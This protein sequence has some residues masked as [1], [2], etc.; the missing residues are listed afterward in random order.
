MNV[1]YLVA[2][3]VNACSIFIL[4]VDA[5]FVTVTH[6]TYNPSNFLCFFSGPREK[7]LQKF[8]KNELNENTN[9]SL[10]NQQIL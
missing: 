2:L 8:C 7:K 3:E 6:W 9:I 1:I 5:S 10:K 4:V